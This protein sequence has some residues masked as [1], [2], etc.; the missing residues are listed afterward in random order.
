MIDSVLL[1][2]GIANREDGTVFVTVQLSFLNTHSI[3]NTIRRW[4]G[5]TLNYPGEVLRG[6]LVQ[7]EGIVMRETNGFVGLPDLSVY[8]HFLQ[9]GKPEDG[10]VRFKF[11]NVALDKFQDASFDLTFYDAYKQK[12]YRLSGQCPESISTKLL[13]EN[14][15]EIER[16][17][18][19][20]R[21]LDRSKEGDKWLEV[22]RSTWPLSPAQQAQINE[23]EIRAANDIKECADEAR[24]ILFLSNTDMKE[25]SYAATGYAHRHMIDQVYTRLS[26]LNEVIRELQ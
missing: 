7:T 24:R 21:L 15:Q 12:P 1:D 9:R 17:E 19:L 22:C 10:W 11:S 5:M 2:Q 20:E 6:E 18:R 16:N 4:Y 25:S 23:W 13:P 8:D 26:R 14:I 3:D